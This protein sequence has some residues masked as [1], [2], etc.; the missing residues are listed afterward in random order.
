M[1]L[2]NVR[3]G[4]G[5]RPSIRGMRVVDS[6]QN[7]NQLNTIMRKKCGFLWFHDLNGSGSEVVPTSHEYL[8]DG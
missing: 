4:V 6:L 2:R 1:A 5:G 7:I 3:S 8:M